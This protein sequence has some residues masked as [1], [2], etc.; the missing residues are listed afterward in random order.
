M[1]KVD[2]II[3]D[4]DGTLVHSSPD[5]AHHLNGALSAHLDIVSALKVEDIEMMIG[6]GLLDL[7]HKAFELS[8]IVPDQN[9]FDQVLAHYRAAYLEA[10]VV[11]TTLYPG[12]EA[13]LTRYQQ[14]GVAIGLCTN[15]TES[16]GRAVLGAL[17][18]TPLFGAIIGGDSTKERKPEAEP[19]L[20]TLE[21]LDVDSARA[22]MVGD[23]RADYGAARNAGTKIILVDWGYSAEDVHEMG[24]DAVISSYS[25]FDAAV[26]NVMQN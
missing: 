12:V 3:Y 17:N 23:S 25:E 2:A 10:P 9:M 8:N 18:L 13:M 26:D 5:I 16:A 21:L 11:H 15:K 20:K 24:G 1:T 7:I 19:L 4:L 14:A 6:G 22:I